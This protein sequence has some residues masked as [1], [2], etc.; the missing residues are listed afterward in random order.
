MQNVY[1]T[2]LGCPK[3]QVD[4]E[5]LKK[6][7]LSE[8]FIFTESPDDAHVLIV[9]TCGFIKEAKEESI[10][11]ILSLAKIK[12]NAVSKNGKGKKLIV[13][14]C[15]AQRYEHELRTEIPEIDAIWGVAQEEAI[16]EYCKS[17]N[18]DNLIRSNT[19]S[20]G[21]DKISSFAYLK[22]AEG[23]DKRCSFCVIPS[24]RGKFRS[25][26]PNNILKEAESLIRKGV[27]ELI[28][29]AQDITS[30]GKE[31]REYNLLSLLND[32]T[33]IEGDFWVRLLYLY[34][35]SIND[36]L[37]AFIASNEKVCKYLDI[38]L[39]HSEDRILRL[40]DRRGTKK[41]YL[42]LLRNIRRR[43]PEIALRTTF[44]V[45][46]PSE[47]EDEF[48][49]LLDFIEEVKFDSLGVF[50]YSKEEGT[51]AQKIK[52]HLTEKIKS[53]RYEE[54]M[55]SQASISLQINKDLIGRRFRA[56]IDE[57]DNNLAIAR[58]YR[59]APEIDGVVIVKD[60]GGFD[61]RIGDFIDIEITEAYDYDLAG[62]VI[63]H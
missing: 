39:Q 4:S 52:G 10:E 41:E 58:L 54:I 33:K 16:F 53:R 12:V 15:L 45:G 40:M 11:E 32:I 27:K 6:C 1:L 43:V 36:E 25:I 24:I 17:L 42:K 13:F 59:H 61:Q 37:L 60:L 8:G 29:V 9:N 20:E 63:K 31:L 47:T 46:F 49:S 3:N 18:I 7:L 56:L 34:P 28:L 26:S 57:I 55:K 51:P 22:I 21:F 50:K 5:H 44:I 30:Y 23:C 2:T 62:K 48:L 38:P 19:N 35:T 14:G